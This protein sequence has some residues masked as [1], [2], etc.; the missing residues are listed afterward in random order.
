MIILSLQKAPHEK[1]GREYM[2]HTSQFDLVVVGGGTAGAISAIAAAREGLRVAVLEQ[3]TCLGG[4]AVNSG[5]TEMNAAGFQGTPLYCGIEREIFDRMISGG[6]A[7]YHFAVPMSSNKEVKID[8]LRYDPEM[9]K[10]LLEDMAVEAGVTLFYETR[11][12]A[13]QERDDRCVVTARG[14]YQTLEL[15]SQYLIDS[16][17]N[18][19]LVQVLG[20]ETI[21]TRED[22]RMI[23]TLMFRI[24]NVDLEALNAFIHGGCLSQIIQKGRQAGVLKGGILAFTPIPGTRDVS[25]NV[26]RAKFDHEDVVDTT[27]GIVEMR[28][29]IEPIFRF[30]KQEVPGM[31]QAY[32]S[33]IASAMGVRDARRIYG[34]Y[35]L[36][37]DDLEQMTCFEDRVA[38][39][40]YPMDFHDPVTN[41]VIWKM[42]PGVYY[43]PYRSLLPKGLHRT[44]AAGKCL[45]ADQKA[46]GAIR[47]MPIMMNV[48]ESSGYAVAL[49]LRGGKLLDELDTAS[50]RACLCEKYGEQ[51]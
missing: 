1:K 48:G 28:R 6:H 41:S 37:I 45:S 3:G 35:T 4:M 23:S 39:G 31:E 22:S 25:L 10:L 42:L 19:D 13:A 9:L 16:T 24:S 34:A 15:K 43:I 49:A 27:R 14:H 44:L 32:I 33:S 20:G 36:T 38:C 29:Q 47:V 8:R 18:A 26:T 17:G 2:Q 40:G 11:L 21:Q 5:L 30:V 51:F 12:E 50:L 7:A 46:F